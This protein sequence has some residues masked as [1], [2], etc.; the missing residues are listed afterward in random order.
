MRSWLAQVVSQRYRFVQTLAIAIAVP[1]LGTT[2]AFAQSSGEGGG[3]A[4]LKLPDLST[5][6]FLGMD[7]HKLLMI[8]IL[9]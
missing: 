1:T 8:G 9:F 3:E 2:T 4:S 5:V 6:S 7:G